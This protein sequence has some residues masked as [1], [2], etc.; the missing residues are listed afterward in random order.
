MTVTR[1]KMTFRMR[2]TKDDIKH[3]DED[4]KRHVLLSLLG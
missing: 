2:K 3:N 4:S 1:A